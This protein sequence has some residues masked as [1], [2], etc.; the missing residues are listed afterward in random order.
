MEAELPPSSGIDLLAMQ[1]RELGDVD[2]RPP[3]ADAVPGGGK[4]QQRKRPAAA[5]S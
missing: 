4:K 2:M 5:G 3:G 1:P